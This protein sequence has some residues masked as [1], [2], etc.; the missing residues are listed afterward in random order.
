[1]TQDT[2][3]FWKT[4]ETDDIHSAKNSTVFGA[5]CDSLDVIL[6]NVQMPELETGDLIRFNS[7][8]AYTS[9]A[10]SQF[11]GLA[12]PKIYYYGKAEK[13]CAEIKDE[14]E[15]EIQRLREL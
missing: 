5:T 10:A 14:K 1:M 3:G 12:R 9:A 8:G 15:R 13:I 2:K 7:M 6:E 11:N 4:E